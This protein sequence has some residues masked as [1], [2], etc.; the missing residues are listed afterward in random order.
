MW[1]FL[2]SPL[3]RKIGLG[4][5]AAV[6]L[7]AAVKWY[8]SKIRADEQLKQADK[9]TEQL[10]K[11][12]EVDRAKTEEILQAAQAKQEAA[13][14]RVQ[15]SLDREARLVQSLSAIQSSRVEAVRAV[16]QIADTELHTYNVKALGLRGPDA[17]FSACYIPSEE[18]RIAEALT[19]YP[20]CQKQVETQAAQIA[21]IKNQVQDL[22]TISAALETKFDSLQG[23]TTR[24]EGYYVTVYN[25]IPRK[26][27]AWKC[28]GL[29]NCGRA[30]PIPTPAPLDLKGSAP[31]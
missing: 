17:P 2:I 6:V 25:L 20:L 7:F 15:A 4:I 21:E 29:W 18:R 19:Q 14:R 9:F 10:E 23:Y 5:A 13:E 30:K 1:T 31:K 12:R 24:L 28:L 8:E 26:R 3:G 11:I 22:K 27:R 16:Q